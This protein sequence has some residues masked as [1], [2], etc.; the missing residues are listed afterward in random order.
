MAK[1]QK[2]GLNAT[3]VGYGRRSSRPRP[4]EKKK[5]G[6]HAEEAVHLLSPPIQ[7]GIQWRDSHAN[8][9]QQPDILERHPRLAELLTS[10]NSGILT[11]TGLSHDLHQKLTQVRTGAC[12]ANIVFF[13]MRWMLSLTLF[14]GNI[15]CLGQAGVGIQATI[16]GEHYHL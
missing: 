10:L 6:T 2:K 3:K 11:P 16:S 8:A 9:M 7:N 4:R 14:Y 1:K 15:N 13:C 5:A 12:V